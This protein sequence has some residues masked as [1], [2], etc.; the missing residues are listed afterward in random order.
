MIRINDVISIQKILIDQFGGKHG[1]RDISLLESAI[2]RP[3]STFD[4]NE[5]YTSVE[6]KAAAIIES[7]LINHPFVDGNKRIGYVLLRLVLMNSGKDIEAPEDEKYR[8]VISIASGNLK[9]EGILDW[10]KLHT[11]K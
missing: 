1:V 6:E 3:Y 7:I 9:F 2:A 10:V 11:K 4:G 5:L 8:F